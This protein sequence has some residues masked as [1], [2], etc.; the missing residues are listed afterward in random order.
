MQYL[1]TQEEF[2][3]LVPRSRLSAVEEANRIL[4]KL[5][6]SASGTKCAAETNGVTYCTECPLGQEIQRLGNETYLHHDDY[7][8]KRENICSFAQYWPK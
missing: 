1:L 8:K 3:N 4:R 2:T 5:V 6:L 7:R